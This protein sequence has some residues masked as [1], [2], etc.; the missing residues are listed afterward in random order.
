MAIVV[1]WRAWRAR[2]GNSAVVNQLMAAAGGRSQ[3]GREPRHAR[4]A[5]ALREGAPHL[6]PRPLRRRRRRP[7]R[8]E[9]EAQRPLSLR[10]AVV[11]DH[12]RARLGQ[13]DGAA[14]LGPQVPA[15]RR[16]RRRRDPRRRRHAQLRLV[17][18]RPGGAD[19]H[20]RPLH[21][22]GQRPRERPLDLERLPRDAQAQRGRASR[23]TACWSR[24]RCP[25]C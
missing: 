21:H 8:L 14:P 13:D 11:P 16:R 23:S 19:R 10:A 15:R 7:R 22:A 24:S 2:R 1:A 4:R 6:A 9:G 20:R 25:T 17:V 12:R 18:H 3:G 5:A